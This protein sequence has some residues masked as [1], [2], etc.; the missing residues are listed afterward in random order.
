MKYVKNGFYYGANLVY[1]EIASADF[2]M[3]ASNRILRDNS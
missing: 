3:S 1:Y 2:K